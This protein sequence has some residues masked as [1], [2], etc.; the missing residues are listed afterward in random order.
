[1]NPILMA[2]AGITTT[3]TSSIAVPMSETILYMPFSGTNGSTSFTEEMGG[4][5]AVK[6]KSGGS[7][8]YISTT[9]SKFGS[10]SCYFP[11]SSLIRV[12]AAG[13][14]GTGNFTNEF[15]LYSVQTTPQ[16]VY[17]S[18]TSSTTSGDGYDYDT[19]GEVTSTNKVWLQSDYTIPYNT[20][21]HIAM[22]N[23]G[24]TFTLYYNGQQQAYMT[25]PTTLNNNYYEI[26]GQYFNSYY[27]N[28]YIQNWLITSYARYTDNFVP[29]T[30][31]FSLE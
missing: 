15:W 22:V 10:S 12:T 9:Q 6:E 8:P 25:T 18:R 4:T 30:Q 16:R 5:V 23:N 26:G 31:Y 21:I 7:S 24:G 3:H 20:W 13:Y 11:G 1:M 29:P 19:S 27:V 17:N 28:C 14:L 2:A